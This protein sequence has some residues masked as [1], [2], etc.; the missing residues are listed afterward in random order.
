MKLTTLIVTL[1]CAFLTACGGGGSSEFKGSGDVSISANPKSVDPGDRIEVKAFL[2]SVNRDGVILKFRYPKNLSYV[3]GSS[4]FEI[5]GIESDIDPA[6]ITSTNSGDRTLVSY[7]LPADMFD[8][9]DSGVA[10]LQLRVDDQLDKDDIEVD[11]DTLDEGI[12]AETLDPNQLAEEF[13]AEDRE[14]VN[15]PDN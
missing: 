13:N 7:I 14:T 15:S 3:P 10:T 8:E 6:S 4:F 2:S 9:V 1:T 5:N 11:I 12:T